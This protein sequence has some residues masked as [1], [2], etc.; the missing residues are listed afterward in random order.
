LLF[1]DLTIAKDE[2]YLIHLNQYNVIY[3]D[4]TSIIG[5]VEKEDIAAFI[6]R[7]ITKELQGMYDELKA[8]EAFLV[9]WRM[10]LNSQA[11][12]LS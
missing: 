12:S 3:L 6:E 9:H 11:V 7:N 8:E 10:Q 5:A 2:H 1:D 4:M